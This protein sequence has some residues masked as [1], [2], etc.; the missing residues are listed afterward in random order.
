MLPDDG[1]VRPSQPTLFEYYRAHTGAPEQRA[2]IVGGKYKLNSCSYSTHPFYG[3]AY[4]ASTDNFTRPDEYTYNEFKQELADYA[5]T[6]ALLSL[7]QTDFEG[8]DGNW[9][10]YTASIATT[11]SILI[12]LW[13]WLEDQPDFSGQTA[14]FLV[15]DHGRHLIDWT[16]HGDTCLGCVR[17][18]FL[19][20]GPDFFRGTVVGDLAQQ[21]DICPTIADL[22]GFPAPLASGR[23]L[24]RQIIG[25]EMDPASPPAG[26]PAIEEIA[27]APN[28]FN[29]LLRIQVDLRR[30]APLAVEVCDVEGRKVRSLWQGVAGPGA[31]AFT[32]D[33]RGEGGRPQAGGWYAIV[34]RSGNEV[35]TEKAVLVK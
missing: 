2:W 11:D 23:S 34:V 21:I 16:N 15:N 8:H 3:S 14:L 4:R 30:S 35:T 12:D 6:I 20:L 26:G 13:N 29:P 9:D 1:S 32:W 7:S 24:L 5:P 19:A 17:L 18:N 25:I 31:H 28:P 10:R 22:L 27:L 33:G